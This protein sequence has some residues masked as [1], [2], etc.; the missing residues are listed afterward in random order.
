M[1]VDEHALVERLREDE[2][3]SIKN[4][5]DTDLREQILKALDERGRAQELIRQQYTGRYPFELLQNANDASADREPGGR[6][7]FA[8]TE[9]ALIVADEGM[10]FGAEQIKA[11]CR[12]GRSSNLR[13]TYGKRSLLASCSSLMQQIRLS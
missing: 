5:V 2:L 10:G 1:T 3:R 4:D 8:V 6:V 13:N 11:I 9:Q 7:L 12:L